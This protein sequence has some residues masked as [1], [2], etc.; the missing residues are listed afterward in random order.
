MLNSSLISLYIQKIQMD[1]FFL[2][3]TQWYTVH[4]FFIDI[5]QTLLIQ[6]H[7]LENDL[8]QTLLERSV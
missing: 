3:I 8:V 5:V 6:L 1:G 7:T 2:L 4:K